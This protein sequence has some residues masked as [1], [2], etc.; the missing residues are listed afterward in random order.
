MRE[1]ITDLANWPKSRNNHPI[2]K[3]SNEALLYAQLVYDNP[4]KQG[5]L[6]IFRDEA[7]QMLRL[8]RQRK[9]PNPQR[10]MDLAVKA[11]LFRE[12]FMHTLRILDE[13]AKPEG[14]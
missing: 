13:T 12:C 14:G 5:D 8:E 10:M 2:L 7:Y 1:T 4:I 11:Q 6:V 9:K 3:S